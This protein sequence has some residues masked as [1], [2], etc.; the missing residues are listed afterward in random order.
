MFTEFFKFSGEYFDAVIVLFVQIVFG[1]LS[2]R[3]IYI[4]ICHLNSY[5]SLKL[6]YNTVVLLKRKDYNHL[7]RHR[8][9][10]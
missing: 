7:K 4:M 8:S 9:S 1:N 10:T 6:Q 5:E 2:F 3:S